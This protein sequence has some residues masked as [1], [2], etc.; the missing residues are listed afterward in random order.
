MRKC[1]LHSCWNP[2]KSGDESVA[3]G[4]ETLLELTA[5]DAVGHAFDEVQTV[6]CQ[7]GAANP[8]EP[9]RLEHLAVAQDIH[10]AAGADG[11]RGLGCF[12]ESDQRRL[13]CRKFRRLMQPADLF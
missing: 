8:D 10:R 3:R 4:G 12:C 13:Y 9:P 1:C 11:V 2:R 7:T 6:E 5:L